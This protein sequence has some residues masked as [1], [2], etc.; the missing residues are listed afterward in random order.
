MKRAARGQEG[1]VWWGER[2]QVRSA[3]YGEELQRRVQ[4]CYAM[5]RAR[6]GQEGT[7]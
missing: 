7:V 5:R 1:A 4:Q 2:R 6:T 3:L